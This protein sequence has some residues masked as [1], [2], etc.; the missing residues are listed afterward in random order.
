MEVVGF[1]T[2]DRIICTLGT[3][4]CRNKSFV[5]GGITIRRKTVGTIPSI[6]FANAPH[7]DGCDKFSPTQVEEIL[8]ADKELGTKP[9]TRIRKYCEKM[10]RYKD[11]GLPITCGYQHCGHH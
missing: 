8:Y 7:V 1:D 6:G 10:Q 9:F 11:L 3:T 4:Y 5:E 2:C